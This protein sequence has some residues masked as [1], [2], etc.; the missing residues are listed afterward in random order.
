VLDQIKSE[1][2]SS[3]SPKGFESSL[4]LLFAHLKLRLDPGLLEGFLLGHDATEVRPVVRVSNV[5][6]VIQVLTV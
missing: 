1:P 2:S 3:E 5:S 6:N 4:L